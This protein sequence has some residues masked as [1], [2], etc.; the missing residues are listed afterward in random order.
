MH[1]LLQIKAFK[2][3]SESNY[4]FRVRIDGTIIQPWRLN[5]EFEKRK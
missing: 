1:L 2:G 4:I 5:D 3:N